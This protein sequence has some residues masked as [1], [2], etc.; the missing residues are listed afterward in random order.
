MESANPSGSKR[1]FTIHTE[2]ADGRAAGILAELE[3]SVETERKSKCK[4]L[5]KRV[6][7]LTCGA[8]MRA[9]VAPRVS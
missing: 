8:T 1:L 7:S 2:H 9:E 4:G 3:R 5:R 6:P